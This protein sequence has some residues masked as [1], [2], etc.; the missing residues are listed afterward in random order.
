M[1]SED[2]CIYVF[3]TI[4][5][6]MPS[7][8]S[9]H[10]PST[11]LVE[12]CTLRGICFGVSDPLWEGGTSASWI[13][14]CNSVLFSTQILWKRYSSFSHPLCYCYRNLN[15]LNLQQKVHLLFIPRWGVF[16]WFSKWK[17]VYGV[18]LSH[19]KLMEFWKNCFT[20]GFTLLSV[21]DLKVLLLW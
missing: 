2:N 15:C 21:S 8:N 1:V 20:T 7:R 4:G 12:V 13:Q 14:L 5:G 19:E 6:R 11:V 10:T 9:C 3:L 16:S 18:T 17:Y